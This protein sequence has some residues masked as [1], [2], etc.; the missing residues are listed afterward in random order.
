MDITKDFLI[1]QLKD[2]TQDAREEGWN[3]AIIFMLKRLQRAEP[4]PAVAAV[5]LEKW[6]PTIDQIKRA[7]PLILGSIKKQLV[8]DQGWFGAVVS[9]EVARQ[10]L[11]CWVQNHKLAAVKLLKDQYGLSLKQAKDA[12][13]DF[14]AAW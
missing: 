5:A 13:E 12:V 1:T 2:V 14:W 9:D 3:E 8:S 4:R 10:Q 6:E 7:V 11:K